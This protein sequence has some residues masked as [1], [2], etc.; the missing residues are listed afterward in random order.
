MQIVGK[1]VRSLKT[2]RAFVLEN[3][4]DLDHV[5]SLHKKWFRNLRIRFRRP[6]YVE[7]R[8]T[9]LFYGLKQEILVR[10]APIDQDH[11]WY[12][13]IGT[14]ARIRVD[15]SMTGPDGN[16]TLSETISYV[17][18][19]PLAPVFW[20]LRPLFQRQKHDILLAD[21]KLL[22]R[23]YE[24][25]KKCFRRTEDEAPRV[26]VYG[27]S[28]FFGRLVVED[29]LNHSDAHI[30]IASRRA[31][32]IDFGPQQSR[33]TIVESDA[34]DRD[35][36][37]ATIDGATVVVCCSGPYQ[38]HTLD[39][40]LACI[41]KKIHYVDVADDRDFVERCHELRN[42]IE[43]AGIMAFVGCSVVPGISSLLTGYCR[44]R[45][46]QIAKT[47][48]FIT[49]GTRHPRGAGSFRCLLSTLGNEFSAPRPD[50]PV[51]VQ[52]WTQREEVHFP[53]PVGRR[54]VYSVVDIADYFLQPLYFGT[55]TVE[56]KIG[57]ELD[58]LNRSLSLLRWLKRCL[59]MQNTDWLVPV[60]RP[61]I[62]FSSL[63][64]TSQGALMVEVS[65]DQANPVTTCWS[66]FREE[67]GEIIPAILPSLAVQMILNQELNFTGLGALSEW[68]SR[69]R[70]IEEMTKRRV[71]V[72]TRNSCSDSWTGVN[73]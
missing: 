68:L 18:A 65:D 43:Q 31:I 17:F 44:K 16:L 3:I 20:L 1:Y 47:R 59:R 36:I 29:L 48:I 21:S 34:N 64:G 26:V 50:R 15:G 71:K 24:L 57:A 40:L 23:V 22:E 5:C 41:E 37:L 27:G 54:W 56:F 6:D 58:F 62:L 32:P 51:K 66:L 45:I 4:M 14:L 42:A 53:Q 7:Y 39:L 9:S 10:G 52:G 25:D 70:F 35:S 2:S 28:G 19:W 33:I 67:R 55:Q 63:F 72:A 60:A 69:E 49:P 46:P 30:V 61:L 73:Y 11:Y 38:G 12:E 8:L 13:F